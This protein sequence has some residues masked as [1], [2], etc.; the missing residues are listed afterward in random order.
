VLIGIV[1]TLLL[2]LCAA[3]QI[4]RAGVGRTYADTQTIP[5]RKVG[6]LLGCSKQL[7]DGRT[8]LFFRYRTT[9]AAQLFHA[10]KVDYLIVSGDNGIKSY[11][12][13]SDMKNALIERGVPAEK[14]FCDYAGFRTLDSIVRAR[15]IF[16]QSQITVI[17]QP[18]HNKRAIYIARH[19]NIDAI[20]FNAQE[21][22]AF[23]RA[24]TQLREQLARVKT[25]LDL[26]ILKTK[27]KFQG[28]PI[29]IGP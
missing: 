8:N 20:G 19:K 28:P 27:P 3:H 6:L 1:A 5:H 26:F 22:D 9:A 13:S 14:I 15:V 21:V 17:S 10:G 16:G 23:N 2:I 4:E 29:A 25:V 12:E 11:D 24:R 18:F 7:P